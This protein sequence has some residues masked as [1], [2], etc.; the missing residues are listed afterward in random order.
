MLAREVE[1]KLRL[2]VAGAEEMASA[3]DH[4]SAQAVAQ[5]TLVELSSSVGEDPDTIASIESV[6]ATLHA[7][8]PGYCDFVEFVVQV[9]GHQAVMSFLQEAFSP[10]GLAPQFQRMLRAKQPV[11]KW[12]HKRPQWLTAAG[13]HRRIALW[14]TVAADWEQLTRVPYGLLSLA[15]RTPRTW[16]HTGRVAL[17]D[18]VGALGRVPSLADLAHRDWVTVRNAIDHGHELYQPV[19]SAVE[20]RDKA[21]TCT[22]GV[23]DM[24]DQLI[25]MANVNAVM[26]LTPLVVVDGMRTLATTPASGN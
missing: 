11:P 7:V 18:R 14:R 5:R 26:L 16:D 4:G 10:A 9:Y 3:P 8:Y 12:L 2:L 20:F 24:H 15:Q 23:L 13:V 22:L 6:L 19:G 1:D 17:A 25:T 21:R